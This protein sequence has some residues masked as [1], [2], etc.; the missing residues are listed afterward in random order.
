MV[1]AAVRRYECWL[2]GGEC[3]E[4]Q[5]GGHAVNYIRAHASNILCGMRTFRRRA[6]DEVRRRRRRSQK[7]AGFLRNPWTF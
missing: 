5:T 2:R 7:A 3:E 1:A 6:R 4:T